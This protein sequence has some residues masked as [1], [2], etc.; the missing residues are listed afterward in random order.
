MH[1]YI[2]KSYLCFL[3]AIPAF[4]ASG[5]NPKLM[6]T[7]G[8]LPMA[9]EENAGPPAAKRSFIARGAKYSVRIQPDAAVVTLSNGKQAAAV[10]IQVAGAKADAAAHPLEPLASYSNYY[11]GNDPSKWREHVQ[12]YGRVRVA[13]VQPGVD[14]EY[15]GSNTQ[16]EYDL[17]L[18]PGAS[19]KPL[20]LR[21]DGAESLRINAAGDLL[22]HTPAGDL[23]QHKPV[24]WQVIGGS[25]R[26]V[27]VR[28]ALRGS[29]EVVLKMGRYDRRYA[30]TIDPVL[31]YSTYLSG[32]NNDTAEAIAVDSSGYAY[33][34]GS[35]SSS[36]FP[37]TSGTYGGDQDAFVTKMNTTGTALV[38]SVYLGGSSLDG[39]N[40]IAI[41]NLGNAYVAGMTQSSNF[42]SMGPTTALNGYSDAF[43]TKLNSTGGIVYS[44]FLGGSS[45][46]NA[47]SIAI[48]ATYEAYV[49][50]NT[51]SMDFPT[52]PGA[53][54]TAHPL[55]STGFVAKLDASA[56]IV[57][58]TYLGGSDSDSPSAI[59]IDTQGNAYVAG[60]T[61]SADFP[62]TSGAFQTTSS[63]P[64]AFVS[65]LNP[66]GSALVYSTFLGGSDDD[67]CYGLQVG[68]TGNAYLIGATFSL[69]FPTTPGAFSTTHSRQN[70]NKG[71]E[72][73]VTKVNPSGSGLVYSTYVGGTGGDNGMGLVLDSLGDV[74]ATGITSSLDFPTTP[75]S[76]ETNRYAVNSYSADPDVFV[77]ELNASGSSL[78]YSSYLGGT[79]SETNAAIASDGAGGIYL[80]GS[81]ASTNFPAT[82]S[83]FQSSITKQT[84]NY[85][86]YSAG[87]IAKI[88]F[89][90]STLC[91]TILSSNSASL[92]GS[93]GTGSFAFTLAPGCPWVAAP[94][95]SAKITSTSAGTG[96]GT[97][98][99]SVPLNDNIATPLTETITVDGG[100]LTAGTNVFTVNQSAAS[101]SAPV[102]DNLNISFGPSGGLLNVRITLASA[103]YWSLVNNAGWVTATSSSTSGSGILQLSAAPNNFAARTATITVAGQPVTITESAGTCTD[104]LSGSAPTYPATGGSGSLTLTTSNSSCAWQ[105]YALSPWIQIANTSVTGTGS[106]AI[107]FSVAG[108][109]GWAARTGMLLIGDQTYQIT[110]ASGP[111]SGILDYSALVIAGA[112]FNFGF[113]G[114]GGPAT[115]AMLSTTIGGVA[116]DS[117]GNLYFSDAGNGRV[118]VI[119]S[120]GIINTI[121]GG[122]SSVPGDGG[123][124]TAAQISPS[125][126]AV[127]SQ[128]AIYIADYKAERVRK[129]YNG[130]ITTIAGTGTPGFSGDGGLGTSAQLNGPAGVA[131]DAAGNV[132]I[133]D[134]YNYRIRKVDTNGYISTFAGNGSFTY[135]GD[136]GLAV[137]AGLVGPGPIALDPLGNVYLTDGSRIRKI[138]NGIITTVAGNGNDGET[139]D[140][141]PAISTSIYPGAGLVVDAIGQIYFDNTGSLEKITPDGLIHMLSFSVPNSYPFYPESLALDPSGNLYT[142]PSAYVIELTP[143]A[144]FCNYSVSTP[145]QQLPPSGSFT[146][147]VSTGSSCAWTSSS[148]PTWITANTPTGTGTG[149]ASFTVTANPGATSR[150]G[151]IYV[152]GSTITITQLGNSGP[153]GYLDT[154]LN[155]TSN[156]AGA[157]GVTGWALSPAAIA[158]VGIWR[159]PV[160][161]EV[162]GGNGYVFIGNADLVPGSRPDVALAYPGYPNNNWGWGLQVLTNELQG[163]GTLPL[164]NGTYRLHAIAVDNGNLTSEIGAATITVNNAG[165][166]AP[167]GTIDTPTPGATASGKAYVNFG[168]ALTPQPNIIA[169]DGSTITVFIDNIA[170]GHPVYDNYRVDVSTLF[171][172]LQNSGGPVGYFMVDTTT[173]ANGI[174]TISWVAK[175]SAGHASGL[176]SRYFTVQN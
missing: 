71:F 42:P 79:G 60:S 145:G 132:Y 4:S 168:W 24:A 160:N 175:D 52:T 120:G 96:N 13:D 35:T 149:T 82:P 174:H 84:A 114:D 123:S 21:F 18:A 166:V 144:N 92:P 112:P 161:Q 151:T 90:S 66:S 7:Y 152:A 23:T 29:S 143:N 38:Y 115:S 69:D 142:G 125:A 130:V 146:V 30:L 89:S 76:L 104:S 154:P 72:A 12:H 67:Y 117:Q 33:V 20:R 100:T 27:V 127:D 99:Y 153:F 113:S 73:F 162:P 32:S 156:V 39:A 170:V 135:S 95:G 65:K 119:N 164:G 118:R 22:L 126:L 85:P 81:T 70:V 78:L 6:G 10:S 131:V 36:D 110:Q 109:Q 57:Y 17:D 138:S 106:S 128:S 74:F 97:V 98:N 8:H 159:D 91:N 51:S 2:Q 172:G 139:T 103:C 54:K 59:Q 107:A 105:A 167:F 49:T 68:G 121:A 62:T 83:A 25:R 169:L 108:N 43:I 31:S 171:P 116:Y 94:S 63:T 58:A 150:T 61:S 11:I 64:D 148:G 41:D 101:C 124:A 47:A 1:S 111:V 37:V 45:E 40:A 55:N 176:G 163:V 158:S 34:A 173:L 80:A 157:I 3:A 48:D 147:T 77:F 133:S 136:G 165:S 141:V 5:Q 102:F 44:R 93:G 16:L 9:F 134:G 122:G 19:S 140:G 53:L 28:Y 155:N 46:D 137:N 26:S 14:I 56:N 88:N 87:F 129:V 75:G 50:G 15:Y 86:S